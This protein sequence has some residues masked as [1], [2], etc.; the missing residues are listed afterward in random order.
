M[1][2]RCLYNMRPI[3]GRLS[4]PWDCLLA[5]IPLRQYNTVIHCDSLFSTGMLTIGT[6]S[7]APDNWLGVLF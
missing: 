6:L 1:C 4:F 5:D 2:V 7:A 3:P